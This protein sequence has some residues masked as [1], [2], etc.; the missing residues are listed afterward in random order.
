MYFCLYN[1]RVNKNILQQ[2]GSDL[3]YIGGND[4]KATLAARN[5]RK[6]N[7]RIAAERRDM[8]AAA[9]A[10]MEEWAKTL[11]PE[12]RRQILGRH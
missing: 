1:I 4:H 9:N 5:N 8:A 7:M 2:K 12:Q 3:M 6:A 11:T 10:A